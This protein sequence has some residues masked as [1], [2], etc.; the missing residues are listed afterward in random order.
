MAG[1]NP[2]LLE[3]AIPGYGALIGQVPRSAG[4]AQN[5]PR[6]AFS[7][8]AGVFVV[9]LVVVEVAPGAPGAEVAIVHVGGIVVG[10][11]DGEF[12]A[13]LAGQA[14][15]VERRAGVSVL[16][17]PD[18]GALADPDHV[19]TPGAAE[20]GVSTLPGVGEDPGVE[21]LATT[22]ALLVGTLQHT[23]PDHR[24]PLVAVEMA[25]LGTDRHQ[26]S[27]HARPRRSLGAPARFWRVPR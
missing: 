19:V 26:F 27:F 2:Y 25:K 3:R 22:L 23:R 16:I 24:Q 7:P 12:D 14:L 11:G 17:A 8:A 5:R 10:V 21:R 6:R 18:L 1:P 4:I 13:D 15:G 9:G 20:L